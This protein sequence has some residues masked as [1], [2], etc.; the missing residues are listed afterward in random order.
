[1][2]KTKIVTKILSS[3]MFLILVTIVFIN[4]LNVSN[5]YKVFTMMQD[6]AVSSF[7]KTVHTLEKQTTKRYFAIAS[8]FQ[9]NPQFIQLLQKNK[10]EKIDFI[11]KEKFHSLRAE[12]INFKHLHFYDKDGIMLLD[13]HTYQDTRKKEKFNLI[14]HPVLHKAYETRHSEHGFI[15]IDKYF[16]YSFVIPLLLDDK[17]V[18][19]IEFAVDIDFNTKIVAKSAHYKYAYYINS[20]QSNTDMQTNSHL[21]LLV[22]NNSKLFQK[23]D[24]T[25]NFIYEYANLRKEYKY[26]NKYYLIH[27]F[28]IENMNQKDY[29]QLILFHDVTKEIHENKDYLYLLVGVSTLVLLLLFFILFFY[30][31]KLSIAITQK[32]LQL[33][34]ILD[35]S[36]NFLI[37]YKNKIITDANQ[38]FFHFFNVKNIQEFQEFYNTIE[39]NFINDSA[40]FNYGKK[41][42][43]HWSI[44]FKQSN[45]IQHIVA[46]RN[47]EHSNIN[48][49]NV[50]FNNL[51]NDSSSQLVTF[52]NI[53]DIYR[54]AKQDKHRANHDQLTGLYNREYF[55]TIIH[56]IIHKNSTISLLMFDIDYFKNINDTYGHNIGDIILQEFSQ[57]IN[58]NIKHKDILFRWGGEEFIVLL[59]ET[60]SEDA[61]I[62]AEHI[63]ITVA[64]YLFT[65]IKHLECSIGI[66]FY[67]K[68]T[69]IISF[70]EEAD[71]AL[72]K[73]KE[74]GRNKTIVFQD[75][76]N[77]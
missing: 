71:L 33:Q 49:F 42:S 1:M 53:T 50:K 75:T 70:L 4:Y 15:N 73:A 63:R 67:H 38:H 2:Q 37:V 68:N 77:V 47:I 28:D 62:L 17:I 66:T 7:M 46:L 57:I 23:L 27:E 56:E 16:F 26:K 59:P 51:N 34:S 13:Y 65:E 64:K 40:N 19:F 35:S 3:V 8:V 69:S 41:N 18:A 72:Y 48:Y 76:N 74:T 11:L 55:H 5:K 12:D 9:T 25:Q 21:G 36:E 20:D 6:K 29:A 54:Q 30:I 52:S 14:N 44:Q 61:F 43:L 60:K 24:L 39:E 22:N 45:Q 58:D 10:L 32:E 31:N